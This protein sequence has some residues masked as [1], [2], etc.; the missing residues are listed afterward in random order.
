MS[1]DR[2]GRLHMNLKMSEK[3]RKNMPDSSKEQEHVLHA[4][5]R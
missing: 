2:D 5:I 1:R 3:N 4:L